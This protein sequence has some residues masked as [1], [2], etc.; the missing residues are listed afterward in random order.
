MGPKLR[1]DL[2]LESSPLWRLS[3][4]L[5]KFI[6]RTSHLRI[7]DPSEPVQISHPQTE[8]CSLS[9]IQLP[10]YMAIQTSAGYSPL[11]QAINHGVHRISLTLAAT[12]DYKSWQF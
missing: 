12:A 9:R 6:H 5:L 4:S 10:I 1:E 3:H 8:G 7:L 2:S 11:H